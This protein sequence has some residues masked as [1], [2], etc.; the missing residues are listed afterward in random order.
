MLNFYMT[1]DRFHVL[2][3]KEQTKTIKNQNDFVLILNVINS[4]I[5]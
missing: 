2:E 3:F 4:Q 1:V 5:L